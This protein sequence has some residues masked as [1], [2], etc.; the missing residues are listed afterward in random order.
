MGTGKPI[1][2][3]HGITRNRIDAVQAYQSL[4]G[5]GAGPCIDSPTFFTPLATAFQPI[6]DSSAFATCP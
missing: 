5:G 4:T 1:T 6:A 2:D 3:V